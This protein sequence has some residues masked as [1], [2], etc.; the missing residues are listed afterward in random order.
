MAAPRSRDSFST[1]GTRGVREV[2]SERYLANIHGTFY[3]IPRL[4]TR[5]VPDYRRM[6]P[7]ASHRA[8]I[9]D[10]ATWRGLL[11]I[12][13]TRRDAV[14]DRHYFAAGPNGDGL[15]PEP[16]MTYTASCPWRR[17]GPWKNTAIEA[18]RASDP[19]LMTNFG[20]KSMTLSHDRERPVW[21]QSKW[22][23]SPVRPG[24][25]TRDR[26]PREKPSCVDFPTARRALGQGHGRHRLQC[27]RVVYL[28]SHRRLGLP[29]RAARPPGQ[30]AGD[31]EDCDANRTELQRASDA[32]WNRWRACGGARRASSF[33]RSG[34][35]CAQ[36]HP[37]SQADRAGP[38]GA[39]WRR[40]AVPPTPHA[41][42]ASTRLQAATSA[43]VFNGAEFFWRQK[44]VQ[45]IHRREPVS[46]PSGASP[47][48]E[49]ESTRM[50][51]YEM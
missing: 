2:V 36:R 15:W 10:F 45:A 12:A 1:A 50:R 46:A 18:G 32:E 6:K 17:G 21:S 26:V 22:I 51:S 5:T 41:R 43:S 24:A 47:S 8:R 37:A 29:P 34:L 16:W 7:V 23:F 49:D 39:G 35:C 13:G 14:A 19:F 42:P 27:H 20:R 40:Q 4:E 28:Q 3:E 9:A 25:D 11:V 31:P 30:R 33:R 38:S 48:E 44:P